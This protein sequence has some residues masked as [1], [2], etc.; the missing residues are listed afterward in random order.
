M[1]HPEGQRILDWLQ[2]VATQR[3]LRRATPDLQER[4]EAIK[5]FQHARF[6]RTYD[7]LSRQPRY[8]QA[9]HFFLD[10]LY[11]PGDFGPRDAQ[12]ARIV[13]KL[14]SLFPAGVVATVRDLAELHALTETLDTRMAEQLHSN[15]LTRLDY[16]TA[17]QQTGSLP[18]RTRQIDLVVAIG[19]DL[20]EFTR[21]PLLMTSL[22]MMRGPARAAGLSELQR[23][24][25][26]GLKA[27]RD[28]RGAGDFLGCIGLRE[29]NLCERL[30]DPQALSV[31]VAEPQQQDPLG[32]LPLAAPD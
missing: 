13:P 16:V 18:S 24:L 22:K 12:F 27:F 8:A 4:A 21:K 32:Q 5:R 14:V 23:F 15:R 3:E 28:M 6:Q 26:A 30:F 10:E 31:L 25:E 1:D 7:D 11:G 2:V 9:T 20:D 17:W 19:R 29:R